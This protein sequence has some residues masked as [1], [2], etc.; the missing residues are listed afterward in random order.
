MMKLAESRLFKTQAQATSQW[1]WM[2]DDKKEKS[3]V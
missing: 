2:L 3:G 1:V